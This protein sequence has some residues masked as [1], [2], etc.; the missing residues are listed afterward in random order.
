MDEGAR[1]EEPRGQ[2][3]STPCYDLALKAMSGYLNAM[4]DPDTSIAKLE[5]W[6]EAARLALEAALDEVNQI[7]DLEDLAKIAKTDQ[8]ATDA[9][10]VRLLAERRLGELILKQEQEK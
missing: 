9:A 7:T 6:R 8:L 4:R 3:M 5:Q 1:G 10:E 2:A